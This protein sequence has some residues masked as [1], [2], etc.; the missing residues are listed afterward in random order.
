[1]TTPLLFSPFTLRGITLRNRVVVSPMCQYQAVDGVVQDW[2]YG[3]H[4]RLALSGVGAA[5]VEAT[6]VTP[7]GRITP[8]CTGLW[9]DTQIPGLRRIAELYRKYDAV[10]GI[11]LGHA[12]RRASH[13]RP[14]DGAQ[15]LTLSGQEPAWQTVGASPIP[16]KPGAPVPRELSASDI[17][18]L[19]GAFKAAFSRAHTAG[20][21]MA[22]IHGA[23]GYLIHSF[24][25]P[26]TNHRTDAYGG[27]LAARM[28][29][30]LRIAE[31]A[32]EVWPKDKPLFYR[33]S[34][35]DG[36]DGGTTIDDTIALAKELK[37][38][39]VDVIDCSSGGIAGST[40]LS[41]KKLTP[42]FQV[43]LS[44][45]IRHGANIATMA[46]GAILDGPQAEAILQEG[47]ADLIAIGRE[48]LA[49]ASWC[50][51]A[52]VALNLPNPYAD[53]P[54]PYA[55]YLERRAAVLVR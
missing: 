5:F 20:F 21:E 9:D 32:R 12:G 28:R 48:F 29:F 10:P 17:D 33:A 55:F 4:A 7:E 47:K 43:P 40:T 15:P 3:H 52:A 2:H 46:V 26:V 1:M 31:A 11:Q 8:G 39:G 16:E 53:L 18:G 25:S 23:H 44:D 36:T 38:R 22:E 37:V 54:K 30:A 27:S 42:G 19:V 41:A 49:E 45:G 35:I 51:R 24:F 14:W 50:T 6:G 13:S 34:V